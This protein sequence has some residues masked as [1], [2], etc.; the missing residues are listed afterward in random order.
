MTTDNTQAEP[1][2][3]KYVLL[4][5]YYQGKDGEGYSDYQLEQ[6]KSSLLD[7]HNKQKL[8]LLDRI[9]S[10]NMVK[11][12]KEDC[13]GLMHAYHEGSYDQCEIVDEAIE[14]ERERLAK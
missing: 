8:E 3:L 13:T 6:D 10:A 4:K 12:C 11:G 1:D 9:D 14:A 5:A 7:W 2:V